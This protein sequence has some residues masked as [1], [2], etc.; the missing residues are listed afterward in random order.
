MKREELKRLLKGVES[1]DTIIDDI[2][3][4]NGADI[5]NAKKEF[6]AV[7]A[8]RDA[9]EAELKKFDKGGEKFV[10]TTEIEA[11]RKFK[12]DTEA[13]QTR[14][15][16]ESAI[17]EALRAEKVSPKAEKL[18]MKAFDFEKIE[19][20]EDG[21]AK[22]AADLIKPIKTE[23]ADYFVTEQAGGATAGNPVAA[24]GGTPQPKTL[25][26]AIRMEMGN[27]T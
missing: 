17:L 9:K 15:K 12:T 11:L 13:S 23:F 7:V 8:E 24:S 27:N 26:D 6:D 3:S 20:G 10:D 19:L 22:N 1:A 5:E 16:K 25:A 21:K 4:I 18:L 2:M 14:S